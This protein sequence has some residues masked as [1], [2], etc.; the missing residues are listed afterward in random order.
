MRALPGP[1]GWLRAL[2]R[3]AMP[4]RSHSFRPNPLAHR[5]RKRLGTAEAKKIAAERREKE[6]AGQKMGWTSWCVPAPARRVVTL[7]HLRVFA[8]VGKSANGVVASLPSMRRAG[9]K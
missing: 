6:K 3:H 4:S 8:S 5:V 9:N 7:C 1:P 2:E